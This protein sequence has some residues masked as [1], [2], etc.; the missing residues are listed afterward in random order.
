MKNYTADETRAALPFDRLIPALARMFQQGCTAPSRHVHGVSERDGSN[1]LALMPAW[2]A[3]CLLGVKL[4]TVFPGNAQ[5]GL[6]AVHSVY[7][8]FDATTGQPL[9][10]LDGHEITNRR[11]AAA[12][13]LAASYL[14][15]TNARTLLLVGSGAV[16]SLVPAAYRVVR[17]IERVLVWSR[18][19]ENAQTLAMRLRADGFDAGVA[20]DL[21]RAVRQADVIACATL[22]TQPLVR[23]AWLPSDCHLDLIGGF[24]PDMHEADT[25]CFAQARVYVDIPEA[26][27]TSGDLLSPIAA[28]ALRVDDIAGDLAALVRGEAAGRESFIGRTIFKSVGAALEDLAAATLVHQSAA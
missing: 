23:G 16:A 15:P 3:D 14:A 28:G 4:A 13:A 17:P 2:Q 1:L 8:L 26:L 27:T 22:S 6:P 24:T 11:T 12:S 18:R 10:L 5:R 20:D 7:A 9:A 19:Y 21:E 25:D